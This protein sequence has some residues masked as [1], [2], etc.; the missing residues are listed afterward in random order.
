MQVADGVW[1]LVP[2]KVDVAGLCHLCVTD[3]SLCQLHA[4]AVYRKCL[5]LSSLNA[6][7]CYVLCDGHQEPLILG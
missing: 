6:R 5:Y 2:L 7:F 1:M 4:V 3:E